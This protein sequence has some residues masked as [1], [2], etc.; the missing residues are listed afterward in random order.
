MSVNFMTPLNPTFVYKNLGFAGVYVIS[1]IFFFI[2]NID[3]GLKEAVLTC[4]HNQCFEQK[5]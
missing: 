5:H 1:Y 2:Q 4:T 3:C